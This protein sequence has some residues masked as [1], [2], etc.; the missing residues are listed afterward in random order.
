MINRADQEQL[1]REER[2]LFGDGSDAAEDGFINTS[3]TSSP[4]KRELKAAAK[5]SH[6]A[7]KA[8]AKIRELTQTIEAM[9]EQ[10]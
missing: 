4:N 5:D 2:L 7:Q 3:S 6:A 8:Q 10:A 1:Q 9:K